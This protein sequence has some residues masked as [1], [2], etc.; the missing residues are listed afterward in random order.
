MHLVL[1]LNAP[2][3]K[4]MKFFFLNETILFTAIK[5]PVK[6]EGA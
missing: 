4:T 3:S 2:L 6:N 5:H 1:L